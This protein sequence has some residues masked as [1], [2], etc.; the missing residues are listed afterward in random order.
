M[1]QFG[2]P[3]QPSALD[4]DSSGNMFVAG[5]GRIGRMTRDGEIEILAN[6]PTLAGVDMEELKKEVRQ[7]MQEQMER[8]KEI[9]EKQIETFSEQVAEIEAIEESERT[10]SQNR[11]LKTLKA[12]IE[13]YEDYIQQQTEVDDQMIEYR[14]QSKSKITAVAVSEKDVFVAT[15][16]RQGSG[17]EVYRLNLDLDDAQCVLKGLRGCCGQMD[18]HA[19]DD[20]IYVAENTKFSVG[21]Y[22]R[23]GNEVSRFGERLAK[24]NQGFGSCCNPMNVI[25]CADG[26]I[27]TAESS[28]GKIKRFD[29]SGEMIGYVGRAR[30]GGGCKH[31][32]IGF[33][34]K[35]DRY[36]VQYEDNHQ[37]CLLMPKS[38]VVDRNDP[39]LTE[40]SN[41]LT[42]G[43][44]QLV[45]ANQSTTTAGI[46]ITLAE[47]E[48][49][50]IIIKQILANS[51]VEKQGRM[52]EGDVLVAV[53]R[54]G[55]EMQEVAGR[56]LDEVSSWI[57]GRAGETVRLKYRP[58]G[59]HKIRR[60]RYRQAQMEQIDGH[61][62]FTESPEVMGFATDSLSKMK[63]LEFQ[64]DGTVTA[65][66]EVADR[67]G[68][69]LAATRWLAT[70]VDGDTLYLD[71]ESDDEMIMFRVKVRFEEDDHA[72]ISVTYDGIGEE[73]E[74]RDYRLNAEDAGNQANDSDV[75]T[76]K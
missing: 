62:V 36:Y 60:S 76:S 54:T 48:S 52:Q 22:D 67:F 69:D 27:L 50:E 34:E 75:S 30:I 72:K 41:R 24:D 61:W 74:F 58:A 66:R 56:K 46:G 13:S 4:L 5:E 64:P 1:E 18:I 6:S 57:E 59:T 16:A 17:Y 68:G 28:I 11:R 2:L 44:W 29:P 21:V 73:G 26:N 51:P 47:N 39:R 14:L 53:G 38:S 33:D 23:D 40:F 70:K 55:E 63:S 20:Q 35:R 7:E 65:E 8:S 49:G 32:A 9:F 10:K 37:I 19:R 3:F 71:I 31:V 43:T 25:C 45:G 15:G 12:Q 42:A